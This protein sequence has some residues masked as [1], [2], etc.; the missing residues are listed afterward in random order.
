MQ[1]IPKVKLSTLLQIC[2]IKNDEQT[3]VIYNSSVNKCGQVNCRASNNNQ[4]IYNQSLTQHASHTS[5]SSSS[6]GILENVLQ[7]APEHL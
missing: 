7:L 5:D 3:A 6:V 4:E 2:F 1:S